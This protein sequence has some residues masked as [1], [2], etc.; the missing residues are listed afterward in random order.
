MAVN[1]AQFELGVLP[2]AITTPNEQSRNASNIALEPIAQPE[3]E[4]HDN[5]FSLPPV[6]GG[7]DAWLFLAAA[8]VV[9]VLVWGFPSAYGIF[10]DYYTTHP[11][12]AG[13]SNITL[14]GTCAMGLMYLSAPLVFG[15][16]QRYPQS[17]RPSIVVGLVIMCLSLGLSSLSQTV[18][19][20]IVTQGIFYAIGGSLTYSPTIQFMD[21]WFVKR[22]GVAYGIVWAGTGFG[23]VLIPLLLQFLLNKYGFRTTLRVWSAVLFAATAPL[24]LYLR[25]RL[26]SAQSSHIRPFN[27]SFMKTNAFLLLQAGNILEGIGYFV[28]PLYLPT[29]AKTIGANNAVSAL[30]L[31]LFNVASVFGCIIMGSMIDRW[32]VTTCILIST[33]GST[34]S[35]FLLWGFSE[36]LAPLFVFCVMYGLFAGSFSSSWTGI[37]MAIQRKDRSADPVMVFAVLAAGRG[38]GNVACGPLSEAMVKMGVWGLSDADGGECGAWGVSVFGRRLGWI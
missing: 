6:D 10:Q 9:E 18:P 31:T 29:F 25:P 24:M 27:F 17:R 33:I 28:P 21:E 1:T 34:L 30:T 19:H 22:K 11:P 13:S 23:G 37:M 3:E 35:I 20:L 38:V 16:L 26:P 15:L 12:F 7:K 2:S 8:F 14:I 5:E 32:H 4:F 36:S